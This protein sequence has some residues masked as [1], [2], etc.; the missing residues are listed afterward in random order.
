MYTRTKVANIH[1]NFH[2]KIK[3]SK[4]EYKSKGL[5][6]MPIRYQ[7]AEACLVEL[8]SYPQTNLS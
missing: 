1:K 7:K 8:D 4:Q 5:H 3:D 6:Y 2:P